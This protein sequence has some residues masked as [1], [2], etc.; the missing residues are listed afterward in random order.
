MSEE[1]RRHTRR[2]VAALAVVALIL[3]ALTYW[4][5]SQR[6]PS[7]GADPAASAPAPAPASASPTTS[8]TPSP[9][10]SSPA[11][12]GTGTPGD[13]QSGA[14]ASSPLD[15]Q[16]AATVTS[17]ALDSLSDALVAPAD[18]ADLTDVLTGAALATFENQRQE[19]ESQGWTQSGTPVLEDPRILES[20]PDGNWVRLQVCVDSSQVSVRDDAGTEMRP[21]DAPQRTLNIFRLA[22]VEGKWLLEDQTFADP[23]EC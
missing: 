3:I 21:A 20:D 15:A 11:A 1:P 6:S 16:D 7:S 18:G 17:G 5:V 19:W 12:G 22:L 4:A 8:T 9:D 2:I 10:A 14:D 23:P 13:P